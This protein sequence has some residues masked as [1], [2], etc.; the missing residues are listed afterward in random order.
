MIKAKDNSTQANKIFE[1]NFWTVRN[2]YNQPSA[3]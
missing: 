1:N 2:E 3:C